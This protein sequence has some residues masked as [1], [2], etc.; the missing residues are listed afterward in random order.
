[1]S[2]TRIKIHFCL[3]VQKTIILT[4]EVS[5]NHNIGFWW[6]CIQ[7]RFRIE[8]LCA[9]SVCCEE[10]EALIKVIF[11]AWFYYYVLRNPTT[12]SLHCNLS[13]I[14]YI[15]YDLMLQFVFILLTLWVTRCLR[16]DAS[17]ENVGWNNQYALS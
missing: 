14:Q 7:V 2:N 13:F 5:W 1:M 3:C 17:I 9:F 10:S 4:E 8:R 12:Q 11:L 16:N 15:T 6:W